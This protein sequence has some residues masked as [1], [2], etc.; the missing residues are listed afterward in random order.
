MAPWLSVA[1]AA[2]A[3]PPSS[4]QVE[5]PA[6]P[7]VVPP[8]L[9]HGASLAYPEAAAGLHG[10]V[11]TRVSLDAN[12]QITA[13]EVT[14]GEPVFH[15]E[16]IRASWTLRF[17][18]A[19][20]DGQPVPSTSLV[21]F[22]FAPPEAPTEA[23]EEDYEVVEVHAPT[24][25]ETDSH[26]HAHIDE[27]ALARSAGD[28]LAETVAQV[29]GVTMASGTT[30]ASKPIIRGQT[31]RRLLLLFDG[32][33][34]ES[35]KWGQDHAPE[36]DP[37][38]AGHI[39]VIKGAAGVR[40][41]PDAIGGVILVD[42]PAMRSEPGVGGK[43]LLV[44]ASNGLRIY[45][46]ARIDAAFA[47]A[48]GLSLRV[49]GNYAR[50]AARSAPDYVLGNTGSEGFNVGA[51]L[52][53]QR[54][55][56]QVRLVYHHYDLRA[57][58]FYGV[59]NSSP[60]EFQA[61]LEAD[62]PASADL[63]TTA[64]PIDRP[65]QSVRHELVAAHLSTALP[66]GWTLRASYAFQHNDRQEYDTVRASVTGP[67]YDFVL[68]TH[69]LD[70]TALHAATSLGSATFEGGLGLSASFQ[71]NVYRGLSLLP[72]H[73]AFGVGLFA[74][75]RASW[76]RGGVELGARYDHLS[77]TAFLA[78]NDYERH[79]RRGSLDGVACTFDGDVATCPDAW[80][81]GSVT[82]GGVWRAVPDVLEVKLDLSSA[83]R[84]PS[85]DELYLSGSAPTLPVYAL[86]RP[87]LGV[88]TTWGVNPSVG[89]SVPGLT[90]EVSP[91]F[92]YVH[93][94]V[95]FAP[96]RTEAG[97]PVFDVT[98]RGAF[99]R[100]SFNP[101][102]AVFWGVDGGVT[103][104][105]DAPFGVSVQGA[106]IRATDTATG[107]F[108]VGVPPD[109]L[110]ATAKA[111]PPGRGAVTDPFVELSTTYVARQSRVDDRQDVA[112]AP[113]RYALLG[114]AAGFSVVQRHATVSFGLTVHNLLN[115][116]YREYTSLLR[117]YA[118][119][120]GRDVRLRVG[121]DF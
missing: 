66:A 65:Y 64:W 51:A 96:E 107:D 6:A 28:D 12:G 95:Y 74:F 70:A 18:P 84:F 59:N 104:G 57:G 9:L 31:E 22:H 30:D 102:N 71:E 75:E 26:A 10:D 14:A 50:G 76:D 89:L 34:H 92:N 25:V 86:G 73:R 48:P 120:P 117:Y 101:I 46:G 21:S 8:Q 11:T 105:P 41:G 100:W 78:E 5:S 82:A 63:W 99:P 90:G 91:Y 1:P 47:K 36:I 94:L 19:T 62:R 68:R 4:G 55:A 87:S 115:T 80:D 39:H 23:E 61:Q 53:Y 67:Q 97:D 32:I 45:G 69:S 79:D 29:P 38:A 88:E 49:E 35:Q 119:Q 118:D 17:A 103:I 24:L 81:T 114:L 112:P 77:R 43:A 85:S 56:T 110:T 116:A 27:A 108:L 113:D 40:Y 16:A 52:Q 98:A 109:T 106:A 3:A 58:V 60:A 15:A 33:R 37:F 121:V 54:D 13:V 44:G 93:Q 83:S 2:W 42:P 20:I 7:E 72:N 111:R